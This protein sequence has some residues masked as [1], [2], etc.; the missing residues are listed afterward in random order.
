MRNHKR[1]CLDLYFT[2]HLS[3]KQDVLFL[4]VYFLLLKIITNVIITVKAMAVTPISAEK[5]MYIIL[6]KSGSIISLASSFVG[7]NHIC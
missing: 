5:S 6:I 7:G 2:T 1:G 4:L 3:A